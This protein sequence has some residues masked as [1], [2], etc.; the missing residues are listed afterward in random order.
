[1]QNIVP[2][3]FPFPPFH[4]KKEKMVTFSSRSLQYMKAANTVLSDKSK[5]QMPRKCAERAGL[6]RNTTTTGNNNDYNG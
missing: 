4:V 5:W 2:T 1:M 6:R 3:P